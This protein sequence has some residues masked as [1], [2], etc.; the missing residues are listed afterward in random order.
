MMVLHAAKDKEK[1]LIFSCNQLE[2]IDN[3]ISTQREYLSYCP[4]CFD[5]SQTAPKYRYKA[6]QKY[7][8]RWCVFF[9]E[10]QVWEIQEQ[11]DLTLSSETVKKRISEH[12]E[13]DYKCSFKTWKNNGNH[14]YP[15]KIKELEKRIISSVLKQVSSSTI[16]PNTKSCKQI[17]KPR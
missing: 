13:F 5:Y 2:H 3:T 16:S 1:D 12:M 10:V 6:I 17:W 15:S 4:S 11:I 7:S 14:K 8:H 9:S